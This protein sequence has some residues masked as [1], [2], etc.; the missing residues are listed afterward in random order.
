MGTESTGVDTTTR[1][2]SFCRLCVAVCGIEVE[3]DTASARVVAVRGDDEHP[4]SAG[5]TC[6]KGRALGEL[7]AGPTRLVAPHLRRAAGRALEPASWDEVFADIETRVA[8][9]V[10][11]AGPG[12]VGFFTGGGIM[13]DAGAYFASRRLIRGTATRHVYSTMSIDSAAKYR[14]SELM[15]DTYALMPAADPDAKLVILVGTNPVVSH[16]QTPMFENP[17]ERMRRTTATADVWVVDPR[18]SE[19]A[20]QADHHLAVRPGTDHALF[21]FLVRELLADPV[22][23]AGAAG[24]A[25]GV[26]ELAAAVAPFDLARAAAVTGVP[27]DDLA[28][29]LAAVVATGRVAVLSGTGVTMGAAGNVTE[30]LIRALLV[31][32]DSFD[33]PGGMWCNPGYFARLDERY[34]VPRPTNHDVRPPT[35]PDLAPLMG[36]WPAA[37]V[38][39]E[40]EAGHLR[41]LIV[42]G[43]N[44]AV[45]LPDTDRVRAALA[46]LDVLVTVDIEENETTALATHVLPGRAQLERADVGLLTDLFNPVVTATYTP[47]VLPPP[48]DTRPAWWILD[49]LGR[50]LGVD[51]L[52]AALDAD[53]ATDDDVLALA[54]GAGTVARLRDGER[55]WDV[56]TG[57]KFDWIDERHAPERRQ[58]APAPLVA[59]LAELS[60]PG[61]P[62]ELVLTPRRQPRRM[63]GR[64]M[65]DGDRAEALVHPADA[66]VAGVADGDLVELANA[67]GSLRLVAR[68]TDATREGAVSVPH[69][70]GDCNV[71]RLVSADDLD[72]LTG[73]PR[74]AGTAIS[75]HRVTPGQ[76]VSPSVSVS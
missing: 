48:G 30:W 9:V 3:L 64:T 53:V 69:G 66:A 40:I 33:R 6:A 14:V 45:S 59:Q 28:A 25:A 29:L 18:R 62:G 21:A 24:R 42:L 51:V 49:R 31:I 4:V 43:S 2:R 37:L 56:R 26:D 5:Y 41:A 50:T 44:P 68:V 15:A 27:T 34:A 54:V 8:D 71:N 61:R 46:Q 38:P 13:L 20:R 57:P 55:P 52:P 65:R 63:N 75:L 58:L 12:A 11:T 7:H 32:T 35:R 60:V 67:V 36:E 23:R 73:M 72:P 47:A 17:V 39:A 19:A 10:R 70:W 74:M 1:Q 76:H 16:G 22:R